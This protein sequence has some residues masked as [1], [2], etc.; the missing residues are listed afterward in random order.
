[1]ESYLKDVIR[2]FN[3]KGELTEAKVVNSGHIN[4]TYCI[5]LSQNSACNTKLSYILQRINHNVFKKPEKVMDNII[6]V[7][8]H[9]RK[10]II[11]AGGNPDRETLKRCV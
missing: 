4:D 10:K 3:V 9:L 7:T 1:M 2:F 11:A 5:S 8:N 6:K